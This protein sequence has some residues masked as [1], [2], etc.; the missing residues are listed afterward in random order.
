[1][2][3]KKGKLCSIKIIWA[4]HTIKLTLKAELR[5]T[6]PQNSIFNP[7]KIQKPSERWTKTHHKLERE[8]IE[9]HTLKAHPCLHKVITQV[10]GLQFLPLILCLLLVDVLNGNSEFQ[11]DGTSK[12]PHQGSLLLVDKKLSMSIIQCDY[13]PWVHMILVNWFGT[14]FLNRI[15]VLC[16]RLPNHT[17]KCSPDPLLYTRISL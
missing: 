8:K 13:Y 12:P 7:W 11:K 6:W 17:T 4:T 16:Q 5:K 3:V 14:F 1:M 10:K 9:L 2:W 15:H